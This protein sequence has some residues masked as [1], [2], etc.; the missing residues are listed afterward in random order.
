MGLD[1]SPGER[2]IFKFGREQLGHDNRRFDPLRTHSGHRSKPTLGGRQ[3]GF[4]VRGG[5]FIEQDRHAKLLGHALQA[6]GQIDRGPEHSHLRLVLGANLPCDGLA[7]ADA[8]PNVKAVQQTVTGKIC[9][10]K[11]RLIMK[12]LEI[13]L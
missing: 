9:F 3:V 10:S 13:N 12:R 6:G 5:L 7:A 11:K 2:R 8:D 4:D 1:I